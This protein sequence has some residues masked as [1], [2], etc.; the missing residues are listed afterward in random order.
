VPRVNVPLTVLQPNTATAPPA[1]TAL[2]VANG[3]EIDW[4]SNDEAVLLDINNTAT[5]AK[6]VTVKKGTAETTL[7]GIADQTFSVPAAGRRL[8]AVRESSKWTQPGQKLW[9]D[10]EAGTTGTIIAYKLPA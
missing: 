6:N 2:D 1:G 5:A 4:A 7:G 3:H 9:L 8:F 10:L